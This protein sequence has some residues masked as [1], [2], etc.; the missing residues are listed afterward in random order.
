MGRYP[1][2]EGKALVYYISSKGRKGQEIFKDDQDK[3]YFI[4]LLKQQRIKSKLTFYGYVL[5]PEFYGCVLETCKNN[6]VRSM[7]RIHSSYANYFNRRHRCRNKL[8]HD[9]YKVYI[10]DKKIYLP[11][12]SRYLHLLPVKAGVVKSPIHYEWSSLPGYV[13]NE[14]REDWIAYG[15][16]LGLFNGANQKAGFNYQKYVDT[17][18]K[19]QISSPFKDLK[20]TIILG[21]EQFKK[22]IYKNQQSNRFAS[23]EEELALARKIIAL[24]NQVPSWPDAKKK[25]RRAS[26]TSLMRNAAIYFIKQFTDLSNSQI[27]RFFKSLEKSS[28]SQMSRRFTLAKD[29]SKSLKK[30]SGALESRIRTAALNK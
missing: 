8:F 5:L 28:I 21:S 16:I 13:Y 30:I 10:I 15:T 2:I 22:D 29:S 14:K 6:L 19:E 17:G 11:K 18:T 24:V 27:S 25:G 1:R 9:R 12:V 7:H 4:N 20:E 3:I 23:Q 26:S